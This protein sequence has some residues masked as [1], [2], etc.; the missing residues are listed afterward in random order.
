[1]VTA[2]TFAIAAIA[3]AVIAEIAARQKVVPISRLRDPQV[4]YLC[5]KREAVMEQSVA[6]PSL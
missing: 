2:R 1:M 3:A 5:A 4:E 6:N